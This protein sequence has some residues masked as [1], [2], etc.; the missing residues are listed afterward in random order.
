[1]SDNDVTGKNAVTSSHSVTVGNT[2]HRGVVVSGGIAAAVVAA[3]IA[4]TAA[5]PAT[6]VAND[7]S[8]LERTIIDS[9][10]A[11]S[12]PKGSTI[13]EGTVGTQLNPRSNRKRYNNNNPP[14]RSNNW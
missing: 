13:G 12:G 9:E 1:M 10:P 2:R 14:L 6:V 3:A 4:F 11:A 7:R 5:E 8:E